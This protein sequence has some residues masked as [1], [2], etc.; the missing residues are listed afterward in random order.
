MRDLGRH[1][2]P[3]RHLPQP[4]VRVPAPPLYR[5]PRRSRRSGRAGA[6]GMAHPC[7][8]AEMNIGDRVR[9]YSGDEGDIVAIEQKP[10]Y[11]SHTVR[12]ADGR[13]VH[14]PT[15]ML[16]KI[17]EEPM[18]DTPAANLPAVR[19]TPADPTPDELAVFRTVGHWLALA[20]TGEDTPK[21]K[22]AAAALRLYYANEL[23]LPPLAAA[24][25]SV[26]HGR[27]FVG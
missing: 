2:P 6:G 26:I 21:A 17:G 27:V 4:P 24:E 19:E 25:L 12:L 20:E 3:H 10:D 8:P 14:Y 13:E 22:G 9:S 18:P 15:S 7:G 23:G 1:R 5:L 11:V 16:R